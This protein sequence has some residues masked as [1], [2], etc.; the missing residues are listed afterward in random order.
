MDPGDS[1]VFRVAGPIGQLTE[2][3]AERCC[4]FSVDQ[5]AGGDSPLWCGSGS[6]RYPQEQFLLQGFVLLPFPFIHA[7][8]GGVHDAFRHFEEVHRFHTDG[9][10]GNLPVDFLLRPGQGLPG[11][12]LIGVPFVR[13][14]VGFPVAADEAAEALAQIQ[15]P[16]L[17]K[18]VHQAVSCGRAGKPDNP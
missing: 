16:I 18:Q 14:K 4:V 15:H 1:S 10:I 13:L 5:C 6:A 11:E 7:D 3:A 9:N 17:R 2:F 8:F 12:D